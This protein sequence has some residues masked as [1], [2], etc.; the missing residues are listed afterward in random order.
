MEVVAAEGIGGVAGAGDQAGDLLLDLECL[1]AVAGRLGRRRP[2]WSMCTGMLGNGTV[3][4]SLLGMVRVRAKGR[5]L[6]G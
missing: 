2:L 3:T 6:T 4:V 5:P 1:G